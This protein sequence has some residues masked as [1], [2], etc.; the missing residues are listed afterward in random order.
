M[1]VAM[2]KGRAGPELRGR[3]V[4]RAALDRLLDEVRAGQS[5][6]LVLR[7]EAGIGK[8]AL[9]DYLQGQASGCRV[10]RAAGV[11]SEM[12]IAVARV[13]QLCAPMLAHVEELPGPQRDALCIAFG[14]TIGEAADRFLVAVAVLSLLS[15]VAEERPLVCLVDD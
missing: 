15:A 9:L 11:G 14:L 8:T 1:A 5:R 4:E 2:S 6:V 12:E 10:A 7:G 3:R 13:H